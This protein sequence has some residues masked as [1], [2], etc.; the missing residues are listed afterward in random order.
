MGAF[1][2]MFVARHDDDL[3]LRVVAAGG[4]RQRD[5][6]HDRHVDVG[7]EQVELALLQMRQRVGA[8]L[9]HR[10]FVAALLQ[11]PGDEFPER[12]LVLRDKDFRHQR[13]P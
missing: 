9:A 1:D 6:V 12:Q 7:E 3:H 8:V 4:Q 11:P 5:A 10:D 2:L 13:E